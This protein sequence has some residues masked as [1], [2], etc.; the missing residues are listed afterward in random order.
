MNRPDDI[1]ADRADEERDVR[2]LLADVGIGAG[3]ATS[4]RQ[5]VERIMWAAFEV[6]SDPGD[7]KTAAV[8]PITILAAPQ[9]ETP[10]ED[11]DRPIPQR[12]ATRLLL[13]AAILL[14]ALGAAGLLGN[15]VGESGS[16]ASPPEADRTTL[17]IGDTGVSFDVLSNYEFQR[18]G[19]DLVTFTAGRQSISSHRRIIVAQTATTFDGLDP[20]T[21]FTSADLVVEAIHTAPGS[22]AWLVS[23]SDGGCAAGEDCIVIAELADGSPLSIPSYSRIDVYDNDERDPIVV[24]THLGS[25]NAGPAL[26]GVELTR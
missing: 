26:I 1:S 24:I 4:E 11:P 14:A 3:P 5:R 9:N 19:P 7:P 25:P 18:L 22:S 12:P 8:Q 10:R 13:W 17:L 15:V 6:A 16:P 23:A 20:E 2:R 21:F